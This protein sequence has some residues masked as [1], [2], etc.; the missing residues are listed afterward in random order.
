[1]IYDHMS[2]TSAKFLRIIVECRVLP[3]G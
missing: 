1:M 2:S 3:A